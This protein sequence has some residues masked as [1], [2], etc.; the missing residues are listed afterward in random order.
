MATQPL[1]YEPDFITS[2]GDS[3]LDILEEKQIDQKELAARIGLTPK[4]INQI[5]KGDAP[6]TPPTAV[7]LE[8]VLKVPARF[9][10]QREARYRE[11]ISKQIHLE[12]MQAP[13]VE[14]W[15]KQFPYPQMSKL[16][17]VMSVNQRGKA[18]NMAKAQSLLDFFGISDPD[19]WKAIWYDREVAFR[20][21]IEGTKAPHATSAWLR[22]GEVH[23]HGVNAPAFDKAKYQEALKSIRNVSTLPIAKA[24]RVAQEELFASGVVLVLIPAL[25]KTCICGATYWLNNKLAVIQM[26]LRYKNDGSFWFTFAHEAAHILLHG[27][28]DV[29]LEG[30]DGDDLVKEQEADNWASNYWIP[31]KTRQAFERRGDFSQS[32]VE[33]FA[34]NLNISAG[35]AVGQLQHSNMIAYSTLNGLKRKIEWV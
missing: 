27:K 26:S 28:R 2:P 32:S 23:A 4:H 17:F 24:V 10:L 20:R 25:P 29:F 18:G 35:I 16:G 11:A 14:E 22:A 9:W 15:V 13:D 34:K 12:R 7:A 5:I 19:Q 1:A 21:S 3:L 33:A 30:L 31:T 8:R 6:I